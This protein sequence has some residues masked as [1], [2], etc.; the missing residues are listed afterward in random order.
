[1]AH[2][3]K[4]KRKK[5][6]KGVGIFFFGLFFGILFTLGSIA[7]VG[8]WAYKNLTL[9]KIEKITNQKIDIGN[10]SIKNITIED[11]VKNVSG[12]ISD[13]DNYTLGKLEDDLGIVVI[14][15]DGFVGE[16][17]YGLDL[18]PLKKSTKSTIK[19][20]IEDIIGGATMNT[21]INYMSKTDEELGL[22]ATI[23][24]TEITYY[25]DS[26]NEKLYTKDN[27]SAES[28]V[29]FKYTIQVENNET[30]IKIGSNTG[31]LT[32]TDE[33]IDVPFRDVPIE[34]AFGEFE[35]VSNRLMIGELLGYYEHNGEYYEDSNYTTKVTGFMSTLSKKAVGDLNEEFINNSTIIQ[36]TIVIMKI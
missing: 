16:S 11:V 30:Q 33:K 24:N 17:F 18:T 25:Y 7:G 19:K 13:I 4:V 26:S 35:T 28:E 36:Q 14:G 23:L 6:F 8:F 1:M 27:H 31:W 15:K 32:V 3:E 21:I 5:G 9:R 2:I 29:S 22:F 10:E 34:Q 12:I 20:D